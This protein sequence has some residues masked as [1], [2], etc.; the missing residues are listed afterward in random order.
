MIGRKEE[1]KKLETMYLSPKFEFLTMYGRRRIGKTTILKKFASKYPSIFFSA[2]EKNDSLNLFDFS[3]LLQTYFEGHFISSFSNW[4]NAFEYI[5]NKSDTQKIVLIIDEFPFLAEPNPSIKSIL[6][7]TIDHVWKDKNIFLILCGSSVSFMLNDV[8]GYKSPLYGRITG[9]ME[10]KPFDYYESAAFFP[11]YNDTDKAL[12]YGILGGV[13]RYLEA[14]NPNLSLEENVKSNLLTEGSF[15]NDEPQTLLRIEL[16]EPAIYNSILE[17]ISNGCNKITEISDRIH[18][19]RSKCSKYMITLKT[20]RLIE[21]HIPCT[22]PES[23]KKG[24]YEITD[25]YYKFWYRYLFTNQNYYSM[26]GLDLSCSEIFENINDYMGSVFETICQQYLIRAAKQ[27]KLPFIPYQIGKWWGNNPL[28]KAQDDIDIL[29]LDKSGEKGLFCECKFRNKPM[30]M[31]E[32]DD[33]VIAS[34]IF[35][36]IKE[37]HLIFFSKSGYTEPVKE[38]AAREGTILLTLS[39]LYDI[40][41]AS[42]STC[43][44]D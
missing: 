12:V 28:I 20:L 42:E 44:H 9:N 2:Q 31:E 4:E 27:H 8:M 15:L 21:K 5:S 36:R 24:I 19:D 18:E 43:L 3:K 22:E 25:N 38:R 11:D 35:T 10:I 1:L 14:F 33:L 32:Y 17:S 26:L 40:M 37:K 16:R 34:G 41:S 6:Q 30:P 29:A 39:D 13:P 23:S 7:H